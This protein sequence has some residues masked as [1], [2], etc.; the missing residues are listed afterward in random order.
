MNDDKKLELSYHEAIE[1]YDLI[2]DAQDYYLEKINEYHG[3][4]DEQDEYIDGLEKCRRIETLFAHYFDEV[5]GKE[6]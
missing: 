6:K 4:E 2:T 3:N 1:A 5:R